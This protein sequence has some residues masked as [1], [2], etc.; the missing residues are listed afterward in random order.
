MEFQMN[1]NWNRLCDIT[2]KN[3]NEKEDKIQKV[4]EDVFAVLFGY[5]PLEEEIDS[6]RILHIGSTYR[7]IPDIIMRDSSGNKDLFIVELKQLNLRYDKKYE[8]IPLW[9]R[10][11]AQDNDLLLVLF[12]TENPNK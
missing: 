6:H 5:D 11:Y 12:G 10:K 2:K 4:F 9:F 7:V 1:S 8:E 3:Y